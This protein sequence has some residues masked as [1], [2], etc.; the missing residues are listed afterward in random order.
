MTDD[1]DDAARAQITKSLSDGRQAHGHTQG[2]TH[3]GPV[4]ETDEAFARI[5]A[6]LQ[7]L[8]PDDVDGKVRL[9]GLAD[10]PSGS[11][12]RR[13][14]EC[15]YFLLHRRWCDMPELRLPVEPDWHCLLWRI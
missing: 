10:H 4:P 1:T 11:E 9:S 5:R 15:M 7:A 14:R 13:C 6:E 8:T 2:Q 12:Q 3:T